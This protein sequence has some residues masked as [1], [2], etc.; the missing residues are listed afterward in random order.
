M[1]IG[2]TTGG[3]IHVTSGSSL[4]IS[5][6]PAFACNQAWR[7]IEECKVH[8]AQEILLEALEADTTYYRTYLYL[9]IASMIEN[10]Y[11]EAV[12]QVQ[13]ALTYAPHDTTERRVVL[14]MTGLAHKGAGK[15]KEAFRFFNDAM[16]LDPEYGLAK[17]ARA[18]I[19][20]QISIQLGKAKIVVP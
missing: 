3:K 15:K 7:Y 19:D 4:T 16:N 17:R 6:H 1:I 13:K 18:E 20:Q 5:P 14:L 9:G 8:A 10:A 12:K 11:P 2:K